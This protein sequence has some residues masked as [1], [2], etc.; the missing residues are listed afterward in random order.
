M[1]LNG[2]VVKQSLVELAIAGQKQS[3]TE[4]PTLKTDRQTNQCVSTLIT[5]ITYIYFCVNSKF[6]FWSTLP[7]TFVSVTTLHPSTDEHHY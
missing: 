7:F 6:S 5:Y 1:L 4:R 3:Q 2:D